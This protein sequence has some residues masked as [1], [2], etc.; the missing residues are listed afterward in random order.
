MYPT[1]FGMT[2]QQ[3]FEYLMVTLFLDM[4]ENFRK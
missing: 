1:S 4:K 2:T 3:T